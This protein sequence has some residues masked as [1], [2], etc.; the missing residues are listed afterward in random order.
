MN[1]SETPEYQELKLRQYS[2]LREL[3]DKNNTHAQRHR[4]AT[5]HVKQLVKLIDKWSRKESRKK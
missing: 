2:E 1:I 5:K 4:L 3:L